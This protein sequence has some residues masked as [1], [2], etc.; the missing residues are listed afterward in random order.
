MLRGIDHNSGVSGPHYQ[1]T[2][3]RIRYP[4]EFVDPGVEVRRTRVTVLEAGALIEA[5]NKVRTI[6]TGAHITAEVQRCA[7]NRQAFI[8]SQRPGA[9]CLV[10]ARL[11]P[12]CRR[13]QAKQNEYQG[14]F[15][16]EPHRL[17]LPRLHQAGQVTWV[18]ARLPKSE[19]T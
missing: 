6:R 18:P 12:R 7:Q 14:A 2:W 4:V 3:L 8:P 5:V 16:M 11:S 13:N 1:V 9:S 15:G 19:P 17:F 10:L